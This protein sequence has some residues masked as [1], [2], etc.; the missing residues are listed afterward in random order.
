MVEGA[1]AEV[2]VGIKR[3]P[4]FGLVLVIGSGGVLVNLVDDSA[5][6]LLP[7]DQV[8]LTTALG[9]LKLDSLIRGY[10]G[11]PPGDRRAL[12]DMVIAIADYAGRE[13]SR[14]LELDVN[15]IVV[16]PEGQGVVA[17]DA[18][19]RFSATASD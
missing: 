7:L 5:G 15:P 18:L 11:G 4:Q 17:V 2:I 13:R 16:L 3:D 10:R 6:L 12:L 19:I 9:R 8:E 14:L 1:V